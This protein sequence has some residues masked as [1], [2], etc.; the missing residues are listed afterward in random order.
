MAQQNV[1]TMNIQLTMQ[2]QQ[3][4][5]G[6]NR[7]GSL[8][9]DLKGKFDLLSTGIAGLAIVQL[10]KKMLEAV[11]GLNDFLKTTQKL[12]TELGAAAG[13]ISKGSIALA[14]L[15]KVSA[16]TLV[17]VESL[18]KGFVSL[19]NSGIGLTDSLDVLGKA[20]EMDWALGGDGKGA[21]ALAD[22]IGGMNKKLVA[23]SDA[24]ELLKS[25]GVNAYASL[26][27][28]IGKTAEE[29]EALLKAGKVTGFQGTQGLMRA[30]NTKEAKAIQRE[31]TVGILPS[32]YLNPMNWGKLTSQAGK[33]VFDDLTG[34][35]GAMKGKANKNAEY[36]QALN[37]HMEQ[38]SNSI[39]NDLANPIDKLLDNLSILDEELKLTSGRANLNDAA[40]LLRDKKQQLVDSFVQVPLSA[41]ETLGKQAQDIRDQIKKATEG[42]QGELVGRLEE[43]LKGLMPDSSNAGGPFDAIAERLQKLRAQYDKASGKYGGSELDAKFYQDQNE[44]LKQFTNKDQSPFDALQESLKDLDAAGKRLRD[45]KLALAP[46]KYMQAREEL[47]KKEQQLVADYEKSVMDPV[48]TEGERFAQ[49]IANA[50]E[51]IETAGAKG[52]VAGGAAA[53]KRLLNLIQGK[54][55]GVKGGADVSQ[56]FAGRAEAGSVDAWRSISKWQRGGLVSSLSTEQKLVEAAK[57]QLKENQ[58]A[59]KELEEIKKILKDKNPPPALVTIGWAGGPSKTKQ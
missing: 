19:S 11:T 15:N 16:S 5:Q 27:K 49:A 34:A 23:T 21:E 47:A 44:I 48:L 17:G 33:V 7:I 57:A 50:R 54:V 20:A 4:E 6:L 38:V 8:V 46:D 9:D 3:A 18:S 32:D 52:D 12:T 36:L 42:K 26:G 55:A 1:S 37:A 53:E 10:G 31:G 59:S 45:P 13:N 39:K 14:A 25:K 58:R 41:Y 51:A 43:K 29:A 56:F 24:F 40:K 2:G 30:L 22:A 28:V 35:P